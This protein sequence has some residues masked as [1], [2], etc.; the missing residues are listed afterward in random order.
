MKLTDKV[1]SRIVIAKMK[2][3]RVSRKRMRRENRS[4]FTLSGT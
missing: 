4:S 3:S 1:Q 2:N